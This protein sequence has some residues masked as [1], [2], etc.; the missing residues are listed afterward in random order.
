MEALQAMAFHRLDNMCVY[1]DVNGCQC[2]G[3]MD[4]VM[5]IEP[6]ERRL[7]GF[8]LRVFRVDGHDIEALAAL[9][10]LKSDGRPTVILCDTSP[11]RGLS[12]LES[13]SPKFHYVRFKNEEERR[14]FQQV[15]DQMSAG[16]DE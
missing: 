6:F 11:C 7:E 8:N 14:Q 10:R 12:I 15:L 13:R 16:R 3:P 1:V 4:S 2:D 5:N 9:G